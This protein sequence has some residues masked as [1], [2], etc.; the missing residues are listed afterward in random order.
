ME[1]ITVPLTPKLKK[2]LKEY[3]K[4][5]W[6]AILQDKL[7]ETLDILNQMKK[8]PWREYAYRRWAEEGEDAHKLF[9]F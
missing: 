3:P 9:K 6:K 5:N 2:A 4:V 8:D 7:E 1:N